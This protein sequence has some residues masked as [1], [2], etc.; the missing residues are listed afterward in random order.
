MDD[1]IL[2]IAET[3]IIAG[4]LL[5]TAYAVLV[6]CWAASRLDRI[7]LTRRQ[8]RLERWRRRRFEKDLDR[9]ITEMGL[10]D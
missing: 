4:F 1:T 9:W 8:A 7:H 6:V 3:I 10:D 2:A 5:G